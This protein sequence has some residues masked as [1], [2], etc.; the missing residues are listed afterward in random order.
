MGT[1]INGFYWIS[2]LTTEMVDPLDGLG[3]VIS[4][5]M[6]TTF[7]LLFM[8]ASFGLFKSKKGD[9]MSP[10]EQTFCQLSLLFSLLSLAAPIFFPFVYLVSLSLENYI[11]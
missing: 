6:L 2:F 4:W 9:L 11:Q 7:S 10:V 8:G 3:L 1:A 5:F